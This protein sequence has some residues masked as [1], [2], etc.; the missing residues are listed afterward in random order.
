MYTI[1]WLD[2]GRERFKRF[3]EEEFMLEYLERHNLMGEGVLI[4][5]PEANELAYYPA[6]K[7]K[8]RIDYES[9]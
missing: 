7:K 2:N 5:P 8:G 1:I 9:I 3:D 6:Y 4:F